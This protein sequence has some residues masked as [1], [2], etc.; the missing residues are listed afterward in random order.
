MQL[1]FI[2]WTYAGPEFPGCPELPLGR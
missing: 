2:L 1:E